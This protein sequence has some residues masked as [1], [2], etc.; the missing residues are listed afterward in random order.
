MQQV[1][2]WNQA[3]AKVYSQAIGT[4]QNEAHRLKKQIMQA[5]PTTKVI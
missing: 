3:A 2:R 4:S 1:S 5:K